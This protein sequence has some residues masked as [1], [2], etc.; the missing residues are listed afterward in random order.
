[1]NKNVFSLRL[2]DNVSD[3]VLSSIGKPQGLYSSLFAENP[4]EVQRSSPK[5]KYR[6]TCDFFEINE[7]NV[8]I[9]HVVWYQLGSC[10]CHICLWC[11]L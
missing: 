4:G 2:N 3:M 7:L 8:I 11:K 5:L 1:M 6:P 9:D 10:F